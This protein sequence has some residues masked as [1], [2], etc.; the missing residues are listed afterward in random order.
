MRRTL[1]VVIVFSGVVVS[2]RV[3]EKAVDGSAETCVGI[4]EPH[5]VSPLI[6]SWARKIPSFESLE[7]QLLA[8]GEDFDHFGNLFAA[9]Q[10]IMKTNVVQVEDILVLKNVK[11]SINFAG[12]VWTEEQLT[13]PASAV[14]NGTV[15]VREACRDFSIPP[16]TLKRR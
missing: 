8:N 16:P 13:S 9:P 6:L 2:S 11:T 3:G 10:I 4:Y 7:Q 1:Q 14:R 15:G 12:T 5:H